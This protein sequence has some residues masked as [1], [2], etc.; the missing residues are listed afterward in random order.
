MEKNVVVY[1]PG[2][3]MLSGEWSVLDGAPCIVLA[4][5]KGVTAKISEAGKTQIKLTDFGITTD[6]R[7]EGAKII[8]EKADEKLG[9]T[10]AAIETALAY[11][12]EKGKTSKNFRLVT[13]SQISVVKVKGEKMKPGFGSSAAA[14]VS[15]AGAI[16]KLHGFGIK[17]E[18]EKERLFKLGII[19]HYFAQG[20]IGSG[21][22]V[23]A[24]SFGGATVYRR[25][26]SQWLSDELKIKKISEVV[27][28][29]WPYLEHRTIRLPKN[30][31]ALIGFTGKSAST[32]E[33]VQKV[34]IFKQSNPESYKTIIN[35]IKAC[36]ENLMRAIEGNEKG[37]IIALVRENGMLLKGLSNSSGAGLE[38]E[39]HR[40]MALV[41]EKYGY[42]AKFSGAG[43]GDCGIAVCFDEKVAKKINLGWKK[44]GIIPIQAQV[45]KGGVQLLK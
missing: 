20:K 14:V 6:A 25:F 19:A 5:D 10:K 27:D 9:F 12:L 30:F 16:L 24:S 3:I 26:S 7:I 43:G 33:L 13:K 1:A 31:I 28:A 18:Q 40:K 39:E 23:A 8:F 21:F 15:I 44:E 11:I 4:I 35:S 2:K 17:T 42:A 32:K 36:T 38:T 34:N 37:R 45:S 22:D 29:N 41:A